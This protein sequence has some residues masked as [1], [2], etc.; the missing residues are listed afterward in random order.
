MEKLF[1]IG[2]A[3]GYLSFCC[4][5]EEEDF[6]SWFL[7]QHP[8][9]AV[10]AEI[11]SNVYAMIETLDEQ[12]CL[13]ALSRLALSEIED[14]LHWILQEMEWA[15][16]ENAKGNEQ[17]ADFLLFVQDTVCITGFCGFHNLKPVI[18]CP[19]EG[20]IKVRN[21]LCQFYY[22]DEFREKLDERVMS[23]KLKCEKT[24]RKALFSHCFL[25]LNASGI[26][27]VREKI[28]ECVQ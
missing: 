8:K 19:E 11:A 25:R 16:N 12:E 6:C 22:A 2:F 3:F 20:K 21:L 27:C 15:K 14:P 26:K 28:S 7:K 18:N 1:V 9:E 4:R 23:L 5:G 13:Y 17:G 24:L 10:S